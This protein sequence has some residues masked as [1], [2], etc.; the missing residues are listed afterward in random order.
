VFAR[1][2][3]GG[4]AV[5]RY[6]VGHARCGIGRSLQPQPKRRPGKRSGLTTTDRKQRHRSCRKILLSRAIW[7][8]NPCYPAALQAFSGHERQP[9]FPRQ[10]RRR[11]WERVEQLETGKPADPAGAGSATAP[12]PP[13]RGTARDSRMRL[14][15]LSARYRVPGLLGRT[16]PS[17]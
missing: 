10:R 1:R 16:I 8:V 13:I 15:E 11:K 2:R 4:V 17:G 5:Q 6:R 9:L 14:I 7:S 3:S 12:E